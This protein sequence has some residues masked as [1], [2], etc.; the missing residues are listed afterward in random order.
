[1]PLF[2][3]RRGIEYQDLIALEYITDF[4]RDPKHYEWIELE[5]RDYLSL[6]D[7]VLCLNGG[8]RRCL[9][10][11]HGEKSSGAYTWA[12]LHRKS[13]D[14]KSLFEKWLLSINSVITKHADADGAIITNRPVA[15]D[16]KASLIGLG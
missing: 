9:Q 8:H 15:E 3:I 12:E 11:K 5:S 1:M 13:G 14:K 2:T 6:D 7:I 4:L 10:V 16:V